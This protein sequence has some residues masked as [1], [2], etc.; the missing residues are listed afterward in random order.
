[1]RALGKLGGKASRGGVPKL[2]EKERA[3]LR[4]HLRDKLDHEVILAAVQQALAGGNESARVQCIRFLADLE[5]YRQ[6]DRE[7]HIRERESQTHAAAARAFLAERLSRSARHAHR[8]GKTELAAGFEQAAAELWAEP[9][10][11]GSTVLVRDGDHIA[12]REH[13]PTQGIPASRIDAGGAAIRARLS[14]GPRRISG[15]LGYV[16]IRALM[17]TRTRRGSD[18]HR[19]PNRRTALSHDTPV[20]QN[21]NYRGP[22]LTR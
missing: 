6:E 15:G 17:R 18:P 4:E 14:R 16:L 7:Q 2:P 19:I 21:A 3:S 8:E 20:P 5:L 9:L 22:F 1:M 10:P 12:K 11:D 13:P